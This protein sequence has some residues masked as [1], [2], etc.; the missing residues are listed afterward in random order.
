MPGGDW[1]RPAGPGGRGRTATGL[2]RG[3]DRRRLTLQEGFDVTGW[4]VTII[5]PGRVVVDRASPPVH[6]CMER[7]TSAPAWARVG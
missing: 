3:A 2:Y 5:V 1:F 7:I 6:A 4:T